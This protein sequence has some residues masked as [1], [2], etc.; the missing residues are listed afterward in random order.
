[1][2]NGKNILSELKDCNIDFVNDKTSPI[3]SVSFTDEKDATEA[4]YTVVSA[5]GLTT[6]AQGTLRL[7]ADDLPDG[8]KFLAYRIFG[9]KKKVLGQPD[10]PVPQPKKD[11]VK[12][13]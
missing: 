1:M 6:F 7:N 12:K 9:I 2:Y 13:K 8:G 3:V 5:D 11:E 10:E 4:E